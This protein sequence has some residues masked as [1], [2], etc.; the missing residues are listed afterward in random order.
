VSRSRS[1]AIATDVPAPEHHVAA[2]E[3]LDGFRHAI[4]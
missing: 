4:G 3:Q 2:Q 1:P